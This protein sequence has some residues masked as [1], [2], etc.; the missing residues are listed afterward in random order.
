MVLLEFAMV[1]HGQP[2]KV[3]SHVHLASHVT[4]RAGAG[5]ATGRVATASMGTPSP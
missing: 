4:D 1:P 5:L 2:L 3:L